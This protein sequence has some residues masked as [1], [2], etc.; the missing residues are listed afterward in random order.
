MRGSQRSGPMRIPTRS[1]PSHVFL[2]VAAAVL[3]S[4]SLAL[5]SDVFELNPVWQRAL[6]PLASGA[7]K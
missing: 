5:G 6:L 7:C 1:F 4:A 3:F 2:I